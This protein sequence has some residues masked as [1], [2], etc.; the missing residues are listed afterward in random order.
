MTGAL[1]E[2]RWVPPLA[3]GQGGAVDVTV[4]DPDVNVVPEPAS[5][6]LLVAAFGLMALARRKRAL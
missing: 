1:A 2:F 6:L 3:T 5:Y 4:F